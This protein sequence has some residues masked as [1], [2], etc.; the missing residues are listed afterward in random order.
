VWWQ[1][2]LGAFL[3]GGSVLGMVALCQA[4]FPP[5]TECL[6]PPTFDPGVGGVYFCPPVEG[7][8][9]LIAFARRAATE[10]GLNEDIWVN[11]R[12]V[13]RD[14]VW[15]N[16]GMRENSSTALPAWDALAT[17]V[18]WMRAIKS[19][20]TG[21]LNA[22]L[23]PLEVG[24]TYHKADREVKQQLL[25]ELQTTAT[26]P[27]AALRLVLYHVHLLPPRK[28]QKRPRAAPDPWLS[29]PSQEDLFAAMHLA[30]LLPESEAKIAV[31]AGIWTYTWDKDQAAQFVSKY[32]KGRTDVP[33]ASK[34]RDL[35]LQYAMTEYRKQGLNNP[36]T[37]TPERMRDYVEALRSTGAVL[38]FAFATDW[39]T[40]LNK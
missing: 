38:H 12:G 29:L 27:E 14:R 1:L 15:I 20:D 9:H 8:Q 24:P 23:A 30:M 3:V 7:E 37:L 22:F 31:P 13:F 4:A 6:I 28:Q 35:Y 18:A 21:A 36:A 25:G 34:F 10:A 17:L 19:G 11:F 40:L 39:T 33:F 26:I 32:Y 5:E 16:I 2:R